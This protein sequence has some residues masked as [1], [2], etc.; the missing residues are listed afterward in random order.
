MLGNIKIGTRLMVAFL[1]VSAIGACI[2]WVGYSNSS[3]IS[4]L[5]TSLYERELLGLS[6]VKEANIN[7]IYAGARAPTCCWPATRRSG[8]RMCRTSTSTPPRWS[9]T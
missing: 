9:T 1:L 8:N 6:Y 3:R 2:G 4:N 5:A 7:L